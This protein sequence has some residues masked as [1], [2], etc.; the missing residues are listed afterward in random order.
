[1]KDSDERERLAALRRDIE[2]AAQLRKNA[3]AGK[4]QECPKCHKVAV[5]WNTRG[6]NGEGCFECLSC[7]K[8]YLTEYHLS[9]GEC[10]ARNEEKYRDSQRFN[11]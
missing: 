4:L 8:V 10:N 6:H 1:M 3:L 2:R 11:D 5:F 7:G 9:V